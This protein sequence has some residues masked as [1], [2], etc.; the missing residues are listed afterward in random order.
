MSAI[1]PTMCRHPSAWNCA[2]NI[3]LFFDMGKEKYKKMQIVAG[4]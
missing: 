1:P 4:F 2:A 3:Q